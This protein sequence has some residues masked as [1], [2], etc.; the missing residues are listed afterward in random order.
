MG[1]LGR[2]ILVVGALI[3]M[4]AEGLRTV[5]AAE[6][7]AVDRGVIIGVGVIGE[8]MQLLVLGRR[9]SIWTAR[10]VQP[11]RPLAEASRIRHRDRRGEENILRQQHNQAIAHPRQARKVL[12][13]PRLRRVEMPA[14]RQMQ[15][16]D[17]PRVEWKGQDVLCK[18]A[19]PALR[20]IPA[21]GLSAIPREDVL[22]R[23]ERPTEAAPVVPILHERVEHVGFIMPPVAELQEVL[24]RKP[25]GH[26]K[27]GTGDRFA[28][29]ASSADKA[30]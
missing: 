23:V 14:P 17:R 4:A 3:K 19:V 13:L 1:P 26:V 29:G 9:S 7:E 22:V 28:V 25:I 27:F 21:V 5:D 15:R 12:C 8:V 18:I 11:C 2:K 6:F 16:D 20:W 30:N 10:S 24:L